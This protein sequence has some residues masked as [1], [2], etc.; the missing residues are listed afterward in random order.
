MEELKTT[1]GRI[2][3]AIF[4]DL[5]DRRDL[6]WMF[7]K[8]GGGRGRID[9][10]TQAEIRTAWRRIVRAEFRELEAEAASLRRARSGYRRAALR[11]RATL[12][13]KKKEL[14]PRRER[15]D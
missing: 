4:E 2:V 1:D 8:P 6:K 5:R 10:Q 7:A 14:N 15:A 11:L 13:A 3:A 9:T 12:D